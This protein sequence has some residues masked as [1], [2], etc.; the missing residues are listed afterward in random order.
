MSASLRRRLREEDCSREGGNGGASGSRKIR[1]DIPDALEIVVHTQWDDPIDLHKLEAELR[2]KLLRAAPFLMGKCAAK[3]D[4][5]WVN[6]TLGLCRTGPLP[7]KISETECHASNYAT[8]WPYMDNNNKSKF[9]LDKCKDPTAQDT[10]LALY[11]RVYGEKPDNGSLSISFLRGAY[12]FY[13]RNQ[14]VNWVGQASKVYT[15]R[16]E[17][18]AKN[19][20][21]LSPPAPM[22]QVQ[23]IVNI[24]GAAIAQGGGGDKAAKNS[25]PA[26]VS[27]EQLQ[28]KLQASINDV[29]QLAATLDTLNEKQNAMQKQLDTCDAKDLELDVQHRQL[30][31]RS[32]RLG[33]LAMQREKAKVDEAARDM[34]MQ[35]V[36]NNEEID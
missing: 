31:D 26:S 17:H 24:L 28:S 4:E 19:P 18:S 27:L 23:A 35:M 11:K 30:K 5:Q 12:M 25:G 36:T 10:Y 16:F 2:K 15:E 7:T 34:L 13:G 20:M 32:T 1:G 3:Y 29:Q 6:S 8:T 21:K 33:K 9:P 22:L 14:P